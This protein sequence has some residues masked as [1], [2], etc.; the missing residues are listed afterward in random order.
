MLTPQQALQKYFGLNTFRP[1]QLEII[2]HILAGKNT[3]AT[4][5][6]GS[7]KSLTFQ[8]P[9]FLLRSHGTT[10][11]ISPL[12]SLI[13]DQV[14]K[15]QQQ[16]ISACQIDSTLTTQERDHNLTELKSGNIQLLYTS[17]ETLGNPQ[18]L[19]ILKAIDISLVAIDEAH[20]Y[21]EWGH[22]FRPSYLSLPQLTRAIK[23]HAVLALTAT[24]TRKVASDIRKAFRIKTA[25]HISTSPRRDNLSYTIIP[26]E[27]KLRNDQLS[28]I[29]A[30]HKHLPAIVYAMRQEQC[31]EIAHHL[32]S[33]GL[34]AKSYHAGMSTQSRKTIQDDFLNDKTQVI[35]ATIAF[36]MGVDKSNIRS[37]IHY[38]LPKSPEGW[39]QESGRAGRDGLPAHTYLLAC[40]DDVIPLTN[41]I[42]AR[43]LEESSIK[44]L[45]QKLTSQGK[46]AVIEP[47]H[48]RVNLG[49]LTTTL[50]VLLAKLELLKI[51]K[52]THTTWRYIQM[53]VLYGKTFHLT[54][55]PK[56]HHKAIEHIM[57]LGKIKQINPKN[58]KT[59]GERYD[60]HN[61]PA[62]FGIPS[63]KLYQT[64]L[65]IKHSGE[66]YMRFSGW[67]KHYKIL[68]QLDAEQVNQLTA[69]LYQYHQDQLTHDEL[70]L[71][72]VQRISTTR[73]CIPVQ[74][75][76]WFGIQKSDHTL[77]PCNNCSSCH[78]EKRP[79]KLQLRLTESKKLTSITDLQLEKIQEFLT[80]KKKYIHTP[81]QLTCILCGIGTPYI[82]HYRLHYHSIFASLESHPYDDIHPYSI[83]LLSG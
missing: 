7:G 36:G 74:F 51:S 11:I 19:D 32:S 43:E 50:D 76:K 27:N 39:M 55:Y 71:K 77:Q 56:K 70:R 52:Y 29:L 22:S 8:L 57:Q 40:G 66:C 18:L 68:K 83:A 65:E 12:L 15:L 2:E 20:C 3:L 28:N 47:Y 10:I 23:P 62:D 5:P 37:I 38:H 54:D 46:T 1:G 33:T 49:M 80:K 79:T 69:N 17:P 81:A 59:Y 58:G 82:R 73:A 72:E 31:E 25:Q 6:T 21:S 45:V 42:R 26:C 14:Q 63:E 53:N 9:S 67:Q 16:G 34:A 41:F 44:R 48:T 30:T 60:L 75:E 24:A 78:G 4:L 64:L 13:R 35:V 61:A